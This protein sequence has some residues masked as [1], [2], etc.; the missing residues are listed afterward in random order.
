MPRPQPRIGALLSGS[1]LGLTNMCCLLQGEWALQGEPGLLRRACRCL[2]K[3]TAAAV[4]CWEKLSNSCRLHVHTLML[5]GL[6]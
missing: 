1:P 2:R 6:V 5:F 3:F 4:L